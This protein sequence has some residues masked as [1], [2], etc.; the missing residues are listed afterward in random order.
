MVADGQIAI[1]HYTA[2][3][4]SGDAAGEVVDTTNVDVARREDIYHD[5]RDYKPFEF[6]VG[7][8]DVV[9]ALEDAARDLEEPR[10]ATTVVAEPADAFGER[11]SGAVEEFDRDAFEE[12][13]DATVEPETLVTIEDGQSGWITDVTDETVVVDFNHE[14]A[15]M[16]LEIEVELLDVHDE[17]GEGSSKNWEKKSGRRRT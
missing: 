3:L 16:R 10:E 6:R 9:P 5:Y 2:R 4:A 11:D 14:L 12:F 1:V 15:G 8:G 17:P 7:D 13:T